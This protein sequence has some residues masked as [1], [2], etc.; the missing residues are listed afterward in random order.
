ML[1]E[2]P[3]PYDR[4]QV[5]FVGWSWPVARSTGSLFCLT[6]VATSHLLHKAHGCEI[7]FTSFFFL[8]CSVFFSSFYCYPFLLLLYFLLFVWLAALQNGCK[9]FGVINE[10]EYPLTTQTLRHKQ[11]KF[12]SKLLSHF[13]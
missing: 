5:T 4:E 6:N 12:I 10:T 13:F 9:Y 8:P 11:L 7:P 3:G 1:T 2:L